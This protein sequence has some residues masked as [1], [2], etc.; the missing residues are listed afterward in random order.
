MLDYRLSIAP[1]V[2]YTNSSYR[3]LMR[4]LTTKTLLFTEMVSSSSI[5][6][7]NKQKLLNYQKEEL[8][9]IYQLAGNEPKELAECAQ[10]VE[11]YGYS[12]INLN[13]G[14]PSLKVQKGNFGVC[15]MEKPDLV[16][17]MVYKIQKKTNLPL[18]IKTRLGFDQNSSFEFL[19]N[20]VKKTSQ[21][22]CNVFFIHARKALLNFKPRK[23]RTVPP[24]D[25]KQV[26]L[27]KKEFPHL[28]IILN[29]GITSLEQGLDL[30]KD[31]DGVMIGRIAYQNPLLFQN[32]DNLFF[33]NPN[34]QSSVLEIIDNFLEFLKTN[35]NVD[36][37]LMKS[38]RHLFNLFYK[39]S[40]AK[41]WRKFLNFQIQNYS[42]QPS[43]IQK[44]LKKGWSQAELE[45]LQ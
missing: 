24:L 19:A 6:Y 31:F 35:N 20:F 7:G 14:C 36:K 26:Q 2:G 27:L 3:Y 13:I 22:G 8:P 44:N 23:N 38:T 18:S 28:K 15:L 4:L 16:A 42:D 41:I 43:L 33:N 1:M 34:Q 37:N 45:Q 5:I 10:L 32:V 25:Y 30:L 40:Q 9:T 11:D 21:A 12:G 29:G 39:N 17:E